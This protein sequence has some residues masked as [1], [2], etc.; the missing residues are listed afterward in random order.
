LDDAK[1]KTS[2]L[3]Y[4]TSEIAPWLIRSAATSATAPW[5]IRSA[6]A[7]ALKLALIL[8]GW[9]MHRFRHC[10]QAIALAGTSTGQSVL[11]HPIKEFCCGASAPLPA[12]SVG[13]PAIHTI[14]SQAIDFRPEKDLGGSGGT[15][16][17]LPCPKNSPGWSEPKRIFRIGQLRG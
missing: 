8:H 15:P 10:Q 3:I 5:L 7:L 1:Y 17:S 2:E 16:R 12:R 13:P 11:P 14:S 9:L 4:D 6:A